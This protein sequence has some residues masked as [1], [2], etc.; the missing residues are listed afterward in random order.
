[1]IADVK[2][3]KTNKGRV[4]G[5]FARETHVQ[6]GLGKDDTSNCVV[7]IAFECFQGF[8]TG[9]PTG[10]AVTTGYNGASVLIECMHGQLVSFTGMDKITSWARSR[11]EHTDSRAHEF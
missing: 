6:M 5:V 8:R 3:V 9:K 7:E 2:A 11:S 10:R 1:M 4:L